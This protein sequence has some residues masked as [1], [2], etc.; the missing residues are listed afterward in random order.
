MNKLQR[1]HFWSKIHLCNDNT[2]KIGKLYSRRTQFPRAFYK[3]ITFSG[4][5]IFNRDIASRTLKDTRG[6]INVLQ[7]ILLANL[8][9]VPSFKIQF[10]G[11]QFELFIGN[12]IWNVNLLR[13][14]WGGRKKQQRLSIY[15]FSSTLGNGTYRLHKTAQFHGIR[16][17]FTA[18]NSLTPGVRV[19]CS[20]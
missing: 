19:G 7:E 15:S 11:F 3:T 20:Y 6:K 16:T 14:Y 5:M 2:N 12:D 9:T 1:Q 13:F 18:C 4:T 17:D 10:T 8:R